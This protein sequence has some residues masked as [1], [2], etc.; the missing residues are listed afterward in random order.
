MSWD[1]SLVFEY[2]LFQTHRLCGKG[3]VQH[4][5]AAESIPR[6]LLLGREVRGIFNCSDTENQTLEEAHTRER[7]L[8]NMREE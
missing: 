7:H 4:G 2:N 1:R 3:Q 5:R 8:V 6:T